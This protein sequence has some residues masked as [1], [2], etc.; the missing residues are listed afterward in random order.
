MTVRLNF[1]NSL[2]SGNSLFEL[3]EFQWINCSF[4]KAKPPFCSRLQFVSNIQCGKLKPAFD[5][6]IS[7]CSHNPSL[8]PQ[9]QSPACHF[10]RKH[11]SNFPTHGS[12]WKWVINIIIVF[13]SERHSRLAVNGPAWPPTVCV[14]LCVCVETC[15]TTRP[16]I[17]TFKS[18]VC[19]QG[20]CH[21][22]THTF[23][24]KG[25]DCFLGYRIQVIPCLAQVLGCFPNFKRSSECL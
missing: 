10:P 17:Y 16:S 6:C 15:N 4:S 19:L 18:G 1:L 14:W 20:P 24:I 23:R 2:D 9:S 7:L 8:F 5:W 3:N 11:L 21:I 13:V 22:N 25:S 12:F